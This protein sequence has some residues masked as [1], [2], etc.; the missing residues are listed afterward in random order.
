M[1]LG[2]RDAFVLALVRQH[3]P[4]D[5]IADGVDALHIGLEMIVDHDAAA[6]VERDARFLQPE[7]FGVGHAADRDQHHIGVERLGLAALRRL[8]LHLQLLAGGYRPR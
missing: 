7:T 1:N 2:D 6:L 3:R 5:H 4:A 8:D